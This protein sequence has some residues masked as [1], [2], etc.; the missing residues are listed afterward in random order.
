MGRCGAY[1]SPCT[2]SN[3]TAPARPSFPPGA[4][5]SRPPPSNYLRCHQPRGLA[6]TFQPPIRPVTPVAQNHPDLRSA[7]A[8]PSRDETPASCSCVRV[9]QLTVGH[10]WRLAASGALSRH[11]SP[12]VSTVLAAGIAASGVISLAVCVPARGAC[13]I[14]PGAQPRAA[15]PPAFGL[16][17]AGRPCSL[18]CRSGGNTRAGSERLRRAWMLRGFQIRGTPP[19]PRPA[20]ARHH[21]FRLGVLRSGR[22][23]LRYGRETRCSPAL[24]FRCA[25]SPLSLGSVAL[26]A[27]FV[28][29]GVLMSFLLALLLVG[30][31][32]S[33]LWSLSPRV[34]VSSR[35]GRLAVVFLV[36]RRSGV[37]SRW[38]WLWLPRWWWLFRLA[39]RRG[40][41]R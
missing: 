19:N 35:R 33:W 39:R 10:R 32:V 24:S 27:V 17:C 30:S 15:E 41:G 20:S 26:S 31:L 3:E 21:Q 18:H 23:S 5:T 34:V 1:T 4:N 36:G 13:F 28:S 11:A 6:S 7:C 12:S 2:S 38:V 40:W 25:R 16:H 29:L 14:A 37:G 8:N 9:I 22:G